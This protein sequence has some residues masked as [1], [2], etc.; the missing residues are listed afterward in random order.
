MLIAGEANTQLPKL[1]KNEAG[2]T[3][4]G[5]ELTAQPYKNTIQVND[6]PKPPIENN[7]K[8]FIQLE[9]EKK[10]L[11][12]EKICRAYI[13]PHPKKKPLYILILGHTEALDVSTKYSGIMHFYQKLIEEEKGIALLFKTGSAQNEFLNII[14][15]EEQKNTPQAVLK[16]TKNI[17]KGF[18]QEYNPTELRFAGYSWGGGTID[19]LSIDHEWRQNTPVKTTV[20]IDPIILGGK[21]AGIAL[22]KR[23]E[24]KDS[25]DHKHMHIYQRS[26]NLKL[27]EWFTTLQGNYPV[28]K[29]KDEKDNTKLV[30]DE[31]PEDIILHIPNTTHLDIDDIE[32]VRQKA[33]LFLTSEKKEKKS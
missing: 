3:N 1:N 9:N 10:D 8:D 13:P 25:P 26:P 15:S 23:P 7:Y 4:T 28:K 22:R 29:V 32:E 21:Y 33:Y 17:I 14:S 2:R 12:E 5:K 11:L 27:S 19:D 20:M 31:R 6:K 24:F 18:I 30:K 16:H